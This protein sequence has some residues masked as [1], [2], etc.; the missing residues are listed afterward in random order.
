[1]SWMSWSI[2][3]LTI[4]RACCYEVEIDRLFF[5]EKS[6]TCIQDIEVRQACKLYDSYAVL[7]KLLVVE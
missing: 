5:L 3:F 4:G 6:S 7:G 2:A 1:M